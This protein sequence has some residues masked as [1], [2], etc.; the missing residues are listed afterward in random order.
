MREKIFALAS[1]LTLLLTSVPVMAFGYMPPAPSETSTQFELL[2]SGDTE[3]KTF[4]LI[5]GWDGAYRASVAENVDNDGGLY[6]STSVDFEIPSFGASLM[7]ESKEIIA[8]GDTEIIKLV[9]WDSHPCWPSTANFY[10]GWS[11]GDAED[12]IEVT[13]V[14]SGS[15]LYNMQTNSDVYYLESFALNQPLDCD[16][17]LPSPPAPP[18]CDWCI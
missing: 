6:M 4:S 13:N 8:S 15:A 12:G 16:P 1:V 14:G 2:A 11:T 18:V 5:N 10:V 17:E 9:D 7:V 3:V